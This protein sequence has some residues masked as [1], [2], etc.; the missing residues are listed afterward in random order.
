MNLREVGAFALPAVSQGV[1][2]ALPH[3]LSFPRVR[4][5]SNLPGIFAFGLYRTWTLLSGRPAMVTHKQTG[6]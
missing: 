3:F 6:S 5:T 4:A 2:V 1:E